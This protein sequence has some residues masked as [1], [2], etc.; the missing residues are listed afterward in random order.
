MSDER[1]VDVTFD[2]NEDHLT[3][4]NYGDI[5]FTMRFILGGDKYVFE[6]PAGDEINVHKDNIDKYLEK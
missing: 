1:I 2:L 3:I 4:E 5:E 6:I